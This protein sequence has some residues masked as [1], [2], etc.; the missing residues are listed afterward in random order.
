MKTLLTNATLYTE[1]T[2]YSPG[3]VLFNGN[4]IIFSGPASLLEMPPDCRVVDLEGKALIPGLIDV[5]IH[6]IRGNDFNHHGVD[7]APMQFLKHGVTGFLVTP[8]YTVSR[9]ILLDEVSYTGDFIEAGQTSGARALGIHMEGPWIEPERSPFSQDGLC[10]PLTL[11]DIKLFH[12]ASKSHLRMITFAPELDGAMEVIPWLLA[13]NI[14][15]SIG[16]TNSDYETTRKAIAL[17]ASKTTHT[18]N[19]MIPLHH[20]NPGTLGAVLDSKEVICEM[21]SDGFHLHPPIMRMLV[22][23]K[24]V[25]RVCIVSDAVVIAGFPAGTTYEMDG[26]KIKTDGRTSQN[27]PGGEPAGAAMLL[28]QSLQ[29]L[30]QEVGIPMEDAVFMASAVPAR[31]L[32]VRKGRL[33]PGYNADMVVL[34]ENFE[35]ELTFVEGKLEY[36]TGLLLPQD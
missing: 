33:Y 20:R 32:N 15:P 8:S 14:I 28:N 27:M 30:V 36:S 21:I 6:G 29:V 22:E 10:Y 5:H 23:A 16:H 4:Q 19:A 17:G 11:E 9:E 2:V 7:G 13:H 18:F 12:E 1:R 35:P 26:Y 24:G 31:M 3:A 25:E 34:N